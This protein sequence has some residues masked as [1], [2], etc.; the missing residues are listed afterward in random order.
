MELEITDLENEE[1]QAWIDDQRFYKRAS[2]RRTAPRWYSVREDCGMSASYKI[3][4]CTTLSR[5]HV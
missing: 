3:E 5:N 1:K 4:D 2:D